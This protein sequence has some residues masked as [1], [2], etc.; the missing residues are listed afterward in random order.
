MS[1]FGKAL[2]KKFNESTLIKAVEVISNDALLLL[3]I[4]TNKI[5]RMPISVL[6]TALRGSFASIVNGKIPD[7][8]L[9]SY[10]DDVLEFSA[11]SAFP[12]KG[13]AG[14]I[15]IAI[16]TGKIYRWSGTTYSEMTSSLVIGETAL[17]AFRGDLG[18]IAYQHAL[19]KENPHNTTKAQVGLSNVDNTA[20]KDKPLSTA[21]S[22]ALSEFAK[23]SGDTFS[24]DVNITGTN[25]VVFGSDNA[26]GG[27]IRC[28]ANG[29]LDLTA[30]TGNF[31]AFKSP[32]KLVNQGTSTS[33]VSGAGSLPANP[34]GFLNCS[35][36]GSIVKIPYY[37]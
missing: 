35:L 14:K 32:L 28:N 3:D 30:R 9:P 11:P 13:E 16:S 25:A 15:Y 10:V 18:K 20:D 36:N 19:N 24:G 37:A 4:E 2:E 12:L 5:L 23:K 27:S 7:A 1:A 26:N 22:S 34:V 33:A 21:Q 29:D 31:L 6:C 17:T 8:Q